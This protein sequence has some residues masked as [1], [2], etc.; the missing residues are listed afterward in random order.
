[1]YVCI[2]WRGWSF[3]NGHLFRRVA[4]SNKRGDVKWTQNT[5]VFCDKPDYAVLTKG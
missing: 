5:C 1:M 2:S 3:I 4:T